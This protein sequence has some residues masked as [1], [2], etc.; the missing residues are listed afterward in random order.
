MQDIY[1]NKDMKL[2]KSVNKNGGFYVNITE[3]RAKMCI[4][5]AYQYHP[6]N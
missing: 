6:K 4:W 2:V 5:G 1:I 3:K